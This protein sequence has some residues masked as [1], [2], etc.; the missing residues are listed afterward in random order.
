MISTKLYKSSRFYDFFMK[1]L[2]YESGMD[3]F[4]RELKI[5]CSSG[6]R[7]L[8][9]GC[10]TG[11]LG[12]HFLERFP[13]ARLQATDMEPNFL[14]ATLANAKKRGIDQDRIAVGI[15]NISAPKRLTSLDGTPSVLDDASFDLICVGAVVGYADDKEASIRQLVELLAPGGYLLNMEMNESHTGRLV[16][17]HYRYHNISLDHMQDVIRDAGCKVSA[18][19]LSMRHLPVKLTRTAVLAHKIAS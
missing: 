5:N 15:A 11:L 12:L 7:I 3:R 18:T 10:G 19:R 9:A 16:S 2:G 17:Y 8:D 13:G 4:L 1:L 6:C 14:R